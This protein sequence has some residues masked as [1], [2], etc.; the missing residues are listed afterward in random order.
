M[1]HTRNRPPP[2]SRR[3]EVMPLVVALLLVAVVASVVV[4]P[5][6]ALSSV[7]QLSSV[8]IVGMDDGMAVEFCGVLL[9]VLWVV[10]EIPL[11]L[12]ITAA[13]DADAVISGE[14]F[15]G[16]MLA[17]MLAFDEVVAGVAAAC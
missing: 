13:A 12:L 1:S 10:V 6:L 4:V 7:K 3:E 17:G 15:E 11:T 14:G 8:C 9:L 2:L 5:V 16:E